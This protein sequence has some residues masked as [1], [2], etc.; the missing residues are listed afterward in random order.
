M[1]LSRVSEMTLLPLDAEDGEDPFTASVQPA[2]FCLEQNDRVGNVAL[3][4][5]RP[6]SKPEVW[7]QDLACS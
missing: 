6:D 5:R 7:F 1:R 4:Y 2:A 3:V